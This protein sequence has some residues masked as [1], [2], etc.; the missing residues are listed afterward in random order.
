M[1][2]HYFIGIRIPEEQA[3]QIA[4]TRDSWNLTTHKRSTP[5]ED[6]HLTLM[7]I[8][9]DSF[10][11]LP[12][13]AE[14]LKAIDMDRFSLCL[15][16]VKT[17]GNPE[18]P[19]IVYASLEESY[20]L[21]ALQQAIR[22]QLSSLKLETDPKPFVPHITLAGRWNGG[23]FPDGLELEKLEFFVESFSLFEIHPRSKPRYS[24]IYTYQLKGDA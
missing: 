5:A 9:E 18:T 7:F 2:T 8:G 19:R 10:G 3:Q 1:S 21:T 22:T 16:G 24:E 4:K 14:R 13:I 23:G 11:E 20:Q 12:V 15:D 6:M 17:F